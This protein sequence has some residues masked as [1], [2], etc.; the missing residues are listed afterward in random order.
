MER[1]VYAPTELDMA[2]A[3]A[4]A[5]ALEDAIAADSADIVVDFSHVTFVD[6]SGLRV[7][8]NARRDLTANGRTLIVVNVGRSRRIF[9]MVGLTELLGAEAGD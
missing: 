7:L 4:L 6:S 2:S 5:A 1:R 9:E 8:V 3:P